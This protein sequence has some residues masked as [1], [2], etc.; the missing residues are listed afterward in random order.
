MSGRGTIKS[1]FKFFWMPRILKFQAEPVEAFPKRVPFDH[2]T[3]GTHK[4]RVTYNIIFLIKLI[5]ILTQK[6]DTHYF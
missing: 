2:R 4:L 1:N 6:L 3:T 5:S